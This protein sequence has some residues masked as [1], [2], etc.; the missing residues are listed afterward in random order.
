MIDNVGIKEIPLI[1]TD[2]FS[3]L[4]NENGYYKGYTGWGKFDEYW[5]ARPTGCR[6]RNHQKE[7]DMTESAPKKTTPQYSVKLSAEAGELL[8]DW[9]ADYRHRKGVHLNKS[10]AVVKLVKSFNEEREWRIHL[11]QQLIDSIEGVTE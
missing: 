9:I 5:P 7:L 11:K 3:S 8:N 2:K 6:Y 10:K 4:D 1:I